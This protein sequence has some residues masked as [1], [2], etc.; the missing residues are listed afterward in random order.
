V[1]KTIAL[2]SQFPELVDFQKELNDLHAWHDNELLFIQK[3]ADNLSES[4][5]TKNKAI[6][7]RL[8]EFLSK[9]GLLPPEYDE[10]KHC[11]SIHREMEIV[12]M[13]DK[14]DCNDDSNN[15]LRQLLKLLISKSD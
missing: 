11:I 15:G 3:R 7:D 9:T 6:F 8:D 10:S 5:K 4:T 12:I 1:T 14:S 13:H 2:I